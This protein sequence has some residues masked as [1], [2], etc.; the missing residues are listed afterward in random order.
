MTK[1]GRKLRNS[2]WFFT[3]G[4]ALFITVSGFGSSSGNEILFGLGSA[5]L[6]DGQIFFIVSIPVGASGG[7]LKKSAE[8][9]AT[10][11]EED[12]ELKSWIDFEENIL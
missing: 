11:Y 4:G 10:V 8:I 9:M 6:T 1:N 3:I 12:E 7:A 5:A 2:G